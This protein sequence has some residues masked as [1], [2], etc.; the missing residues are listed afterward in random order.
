MI[1]NTR[2]SERKRDILDLA[3]LQEY[4]RGEGGDNEARRMR[5]L[6]NLP[7]AIEEELSPRQR[8][9]LEMRF[10]KN[11]KVTE[12]AEELG[13]TKSN[14]SKTLSRAMERLFRALRYSL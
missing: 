10:F 5:L 6:K 13:V 2:Y 4:M 3:A 7:V 1:Q 8:Q 11:M 9:I 14:V 12:I